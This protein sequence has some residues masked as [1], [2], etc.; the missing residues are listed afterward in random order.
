MNKYIT[1]INKYIKYKSKYLDLYSNQ[2]G[3]LINIDKIPNITIKLENNEK[4]IELKGIISVVYNETDNTYTIKFNKLDSIQ[5][6]LDLTKS[7]PNKSITD[8]TITIS[9]NN[10]LILNNYDEI[11]KSN[12]KDIETINLMFNESTVI[13]AIRR[14]PQKLIEV[15]QSQRSREDLVHRGRG[16]SAHRGREEGNRSQRAKSTNHADTSG[17]GGKGGKGR[18]K[19]RGEGSGERSRSTSRE[20]KPKFIEGL[21]EKILEKSQDISNVIDYIMLE[22]RDRFYKFIMKD[23]IKT[24]K[25]QKLLIEEKLYLLSEIF[26]VFSLNFY[27]KKQLYDALNELNRTILAKYVSNPLEIA[28][29]YDI[30]QKTKYYIYLQIDAD[31]PVFIKNKCIIC[32]TGIPEMKQEKAIEIFQKSKKI[33]RQIICSYCKSIYNNK[34][35]QIA[36]DN[37]PKSIEGVLKYD[38]LIQKEN[39]EIL[40]KELLENNIIR[41]IKYSTLS[42]YDKYYIYYRVLITS[43]IEKRKYADVAKAFVYTKNNFPIVQQEE[44]LA[45]GYNF[46]SY[47]DYTQIEKSSTKPIFVASIC[48]I[49]KKII[50][51]VSYSTINKHFQSNKT[52]YI[53]Q[54]LC[55]KCKSDF[56]K[57]HRNP[58]ISAISPTPAISAISAI[59][60]TTIQSPKDWKEEKP[61]KWGDEDDSDDDND[62]N[63]DNVYFNYPKEIIE[64]RK[65]TE[66]TWRRR[67]HFKGWKLLGGSETKCIIPNKLI[68]EFD[69]ENFGNYNYDGLEEDFTN[70]DDEINEQLFEK[71]NL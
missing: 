56:T 67:G 13:E 21:E 63:D 17:K 37:T 60:I 61:K 64:R 49:C 55:S 7:K 33:N 53:R 18:G 29:G 45:N 41:W 22:L 28:Y 54:F 12:T 31:K 8:N 69:D 36:N 3:G 43:G 44:E 62:D 10:L 26:I 19:G 40:I 70:D 51:E 47:T 16:D 15:K 23:I 27:Y 25:S 68:S 9:A 48:I 66:Y 38:G 14:I 39:L 20:Q 57:E 32:C 6:L 50:T 4:Y 24:I 42:V 2:F 71:F 52:D 58:P 11:S 34:K 5:E 30:I 46:F 59:P 1:N 65:F 35:K